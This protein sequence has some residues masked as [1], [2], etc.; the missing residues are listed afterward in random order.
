ML[1]FNL[2]IKYTMKTLKL[3]IIS[4]L[5]LNSYALIAQNLDMKNKVEKLKKSGRDSIIKLAIKKLDKDIVA[6]N[7]LI[8][9][10]ANSSSVIVYFHLAIIYVPLNTEYAY[11]YGIDLIEGTSWSN[12]VSNPHAYETGIINTPNYKPSEETK[13]HI[14]F[15]LD[16]INKNNEV[17]SIDIEHFSFD[18]SMIIRDNKKHY[19]IT[20]LSTH[21]ESSYKIDK[22]TGKVFDARHAHLIP[23][24]DFGD[25]N[26]KFEEIK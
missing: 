25:E 6:S 24:P 22:E 17:G 13:K 11:N 18:D 14:Q 7:Y 3:L 26:D 8:Q 19:E 23:P 4:V 20:M 1:S 5:L 2:I 9:V 16:A 21:Q 15:V 10:K 12:I